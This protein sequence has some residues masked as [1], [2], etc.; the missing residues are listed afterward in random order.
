MLKIC[1]QNKYHYRVDESI[2]R[3]VCINN[4][5]NERINSLN[6]FRAW[7]TYSSSLSPILLL[8]MGEKRKTMGK[9]ANFCFFASFFPFDSQFNFKHEQTFG[10]DEEAK[11]N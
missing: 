4:S 5:L 11:M 8:S 9:M 2:P 10:F 3:G 6:D 1:I 7:L